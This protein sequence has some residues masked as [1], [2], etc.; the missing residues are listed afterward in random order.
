M[1]NRRW[2]IAASMGWR[3]ILLFTDATWARAAAIVMAALSIT[4][5][6]L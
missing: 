3:T 1:T 2:E 4:A 6:F 5:N